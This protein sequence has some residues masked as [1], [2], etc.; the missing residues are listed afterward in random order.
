MVER[1][2]LENPSCS[3]DARIWTVDQMDWIMGPASPREGQELRWAGKRYRVVRHQGE[4]RVRE[5]AR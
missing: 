4:I 2:R 3:R 1:V 5:V